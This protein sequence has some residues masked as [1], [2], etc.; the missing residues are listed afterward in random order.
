MQNILAKIQK[1]KILLSAY[2][3][4]SVLYF[5]SLFFAN[6]ANS[7]WITFFLWVLAL[8]SPLVLL[9]YKNLK[10]KKT[11]N[12]YLLI[13]LLI[14][15]TFFFL[16]F[17]KNYPFVSIYDQVRD[18]GLNAKQILNG[19]LIN[20]FGYGR[21]S[22]HGLII[23]TIGSFFYLLFKNSV[24]TFRI[25][26]ALLSIISVGIIYKLIKENF[27][28]EAAFFSGI[29][30]TSIPL[31]LYYARTE[32]VVVYS[33]FL[34]SL[35][36][37]RISKLLKNQNLINY[38]SISI[39]LGFAS[40]FHTS[41]RTV[42]VLTLI[43]LILFNLTNLFL[44]KNITNFKNIILILSFYIIG[45][46]PRIL[47]TTPDIFFQT[48]SI[49]LG[50]ESFSI[51]N[52]IPKLIFNYINSLLVYSVNPTIS[53]HFQVFKPIL[54]PLYSILF[55]IGIISLIINK[56]KLSKVILF[57]IFALPFT[58]SAV[59]EAINSDNRLAPLFVLSAISCGLGINYLLKRIDNLRLR[60]FFIVSITLIILS[61]TSTFFIN[62]DASKGYSE[63]DYLSM[64]TVY[65][66]QNNKEFNKNKFT[67][68]F[69][70][71]TFT[72]YVNYLHVQEQYEFFSPG[73]IKI[74]SISGIKPNEIYISQSCSFPSKSNYDKIVYCSTKNKF[75][76]KNR[77]IN[78]Y[79]E[80]NN[81]TGKI[82]N[83][84]YKTINPKPVFI[85]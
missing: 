5:S 77:P 11:K 79:L 71:E 6:S 82:Y 20:I 80:K 45:F 42:S 75:T 73:T 31:V 48:R 60:T 23:P 52:L 70:N 51:L 49:G 53:T 74:A 29:I 33:L 76:C 35:I 43:L 81:V 22:S 18:G 9:S 21:Y 57:F 36:L 34:F 39:L 24:Y 72:S 78:I 16:V 64:H 8:I 85:P 28:K 44:K 7:R 50:N 1:N 37:F 84:D 54:N 2:L 59:T 55:I 12:D 63:I 26:A 67:C 30:L 66:L 47:F 41:I 40:G 10:I 15:S 68:L 3:L 25:P 38:I 32:V 17:L 69:S 19:D 61:I 65:A 27:S 4:S 14:I 46:G 56:N 62:E 83:T 58:N 13:I